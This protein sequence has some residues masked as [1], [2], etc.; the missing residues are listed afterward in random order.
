MPLHGDGAGGGELA[1]RA[2]GA[3]GGVEVGGVQ[4]WGAS[5]AA[6]LAGHWV[7]LAW[8]AGIAR[9]SAWCLVSVPRVAD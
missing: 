2:F 7:G 4:A 1:G 6:G 3:L 5:G 9:F 8:L